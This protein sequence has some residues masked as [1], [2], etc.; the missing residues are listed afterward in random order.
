V[1]NS[2]VEFDGGYGRKGVITVKHGPVEHPETE[3]P[4]GARPDWQPRPAWTEHIGCDVCRREDIPV[5][6][7][8]P[9]EGEYA[10]GRICRDCVNLLFDKEALI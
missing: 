8:D 10:D 7:I 9:S 5:I 2:V 6:S 4:V 3:R 1:P